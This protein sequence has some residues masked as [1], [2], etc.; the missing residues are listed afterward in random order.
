MP[1]IGQLEARVT[2]RA[3]QEAVR[4]LHEYAGPVAGLHLGSRGAAMGQ[5][6]EHGQALVHDVVVGPALEV[7]HH[8]DAAGVVFI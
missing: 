5:P 1:G 6:L 2:C 8:A 3:H 7:R 4:H